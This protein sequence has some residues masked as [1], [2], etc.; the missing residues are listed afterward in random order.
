M[1]E[2]PTPTETPAVSTEPEEPLLD[3]ALKAPVGAPE[4]YED[5]KLPQG[6]ELNADGLTEATSLFRDL[7]LTQDKAQKLIDYHA[8]KLAD[9]VGVKQ[10]VLD[11][12]R[13]KKLGEIKADPEIGRDIPKVEATMA[14]ALNALG[15]PALAKAFR[16]SMNESGYGNDLAFVKVFYKLAQL[17]TEGTH[18][19]GGQPSPEGQRAP[20]ATKPSA[21]KALFPN[22]A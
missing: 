3:P 10:E 5:F 13:E 1:P 15:D 21:A 17:V 4:K 22:L 7:G 18:V 12:L 20:G 9:A 11:G 19:P 14:K 8:A 16:A 6:F 2:T